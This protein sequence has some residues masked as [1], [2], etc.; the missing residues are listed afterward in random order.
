MMTDR[1]EA[2]AGVRASG[3]RT[4]T[5]ARLVGTSTAA[6]QL[7]RL[8]VVGLPKPVPNDPERTGNG[9]LPPLDSLIGP[10]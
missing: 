7:G 1:S 8:L 9:K 6:P 2:R 4:G 3:V 5:K 10:E